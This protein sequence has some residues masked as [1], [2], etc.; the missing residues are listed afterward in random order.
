MK[1]TS[2]FPVVPAR[3][4]GI[5]I[6]EYAS[7]YRPMDERISCVVKAIRLITRWR[8]LHKMAAQI[9]NWETESEINATHICAV[10]MV[11]VPVAT[12]R[13]ARRQAE[14]MAAPFQ[15][16]LRELATQIGRIQF[17]FSCKRHC[18]CD[19]V[20]L[21]ASPILECYNNLKPVIFSKFLHLRP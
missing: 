12:M 6:P 11:Q 19:G 14:L 13:S 21:N 5:P 15:P 17:T 20:K 18:R 1:M 8:H 2:S 7:L 4:P 9:V 3:Q 16:S 10:Y